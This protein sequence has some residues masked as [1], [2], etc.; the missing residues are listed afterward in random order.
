MD[1]FLEE[2]LGGESNREGRERFRA[3]WDVSQMLESLS[4]VSR[5]DVSRVEGS[6]IDE[7][8]CRNMR[9]GKHQNQSLS[10]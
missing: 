2:M 10:R 4:L 6:R 8:I 1:N 5:I 3:L 7:L 9:P